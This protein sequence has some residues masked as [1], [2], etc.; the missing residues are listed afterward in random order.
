MMSEPKIK[1]EPC[2][3]HLRHKMMYCD[4]RHV[5]RGKVDDSSETRVFFCVKTGDSLG[6]DAQ[7]TCPSDCQAGRRCYEGAAAPG[8]ER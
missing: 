5:T 7:A 3:Q 4:T 8:G 2:C 6:P 1:L